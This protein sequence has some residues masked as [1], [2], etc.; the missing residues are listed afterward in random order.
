M[1]DESLASFVIVCLPNVYLLY[2]L[3][4]SF[5][6]QLWIEMRKGVQETE[7][8]TQTPQTKGR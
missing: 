4:F 6:L 8:G 5:T 3:H 7:C 2:T 1:E